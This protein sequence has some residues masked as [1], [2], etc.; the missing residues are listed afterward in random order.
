[1]AATVS[2]WS[3]VAVVMQSALATALPITG[4]TKANPGV[5]TYTGTDPV[6]GDYVVLNI[7]GMYQLDKKV[8]RVANVNGAGNTFELEGVDT[9]LFDTFTSGT[10]EVITFGTTITTLTD[11]AASGGD[12]AEIEATTIHDT[13]DQIVLGNFGVTAYS[14][15]GL[16]DPAE[17]GFIAMKAASDLKAERAFRFTFANGKKH[18][19]TG[20]VAANG[21]PMGAAKDKVTTPVKI[22]IRGRSTYYAT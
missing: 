4:I 5:V 10:A 2:I 6:N 22:T 16:W 12:A 13:T 3:G 1:M 15:G 18:V 11:I 17:A 9:T 7:V 14:F 20:L 19:F 21:T 8:V